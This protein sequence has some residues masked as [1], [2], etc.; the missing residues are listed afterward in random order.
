M[1]QA[2]H[3]PLSLA[4]AAALV[5]GNLCAQSEAQPSPRDVH[6]A[7]VN[8]SH[9]VPIHTQPDDPIGGAYGTWTSRQSYKASFHGDPTFIPVLGKE[10]PHNL[11]FRWRTTS[12]RRGEEELLEPGKR[13]VRSYTDD[14]Y[15]YRYGR[16]TEAYDVLDD[17]LE[18]TFVLETPPGGTGDLV[19]TGQISTPL[20]GTDRA[21]AH[22]AIAFA[23]ASGA[24]IVRYGAAFAL[25]ADGVKLDLETALAGTEIRLVVPDRILREARYPLIL[26]PLISS[27]VLQSSSTASYFDTDIGFDRD[28][29]EYLLV[30]SRW[31]SG[32]DY[33]LFAWIHHRSFLTPGSV[34]FAD[35]TSSWSSS[36]G[37]VASVDQ[38]RKYVFALTRDFGV[39]GAAIRYRVHQGGDRTL[40]T[41]VNFIDPPSGITDH[42]PDVGGSLWARGFS[43]AMIVL[44][45]TNLPIVTGQTSQVMAVPID[46]ATT[47]P[48]QSPEFAVQPIPGAPFTFPI[49]ARPAINKVGSFSRTGGTWVVAMQQTYLGSIAPQ[50]WAIAARQIHSDGTQ[51]PN[52]WQ[53]PATSGTPEH[54]MGPKIAG[55]GNRGA[56][57]H[58][59]VVYTATPD[60]GA[61][62]GQPWGRRVMFARFDWVDG[63]AIQQQN[64]RQIDSTTTGS[65][66][67]GDCSYDR[68]TTSHWAITYSGPAG[69]SVNR[70]GNWG[71]VL[72]SH[73]YGSPGT[74]LEQYNPGGIVWEDNGQFI[75]TWSK[76]GANGGEFVVYKQTYRMPQAPVL[77]GT[78]CSTATLEWSTA[79]GGRGPWTDQQIGHGRTQVEL[80]GA[81]PGALAILLLSLSPPIQ[82]PLSGS[83][84]A[85]GCNLLLSSYVVIPG[86]TAPGVWPFPLPGNY[87][88]ATY[89]FQ[90]WHTDGVGL[91]RGTQRLEVE[92]LR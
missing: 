1:R 10:H 46:T 14:R 79:Y 4:L 50:R 7:V 87:P 69:N 16:V 35:V 8:A 19:V 64:V 68:R 28:N 9:R 48:T 47:L 73:S 65:F 67:V 54:T 3:H 88:E 72:E 49:T 37:C 92:L 12:V 39:S 55:F 41:T 42:H 36:E 62:P 52:A 58:Y 22:G 61:L 66:V 23:D 2:L 74:F 60:S 5:P 24:E 90:A 75:S 31:V 80:T 44:Q 27:T 29:N 57:G 59:G 26:D 34:V 33:D 89:R 70:L 84:I 11:E 86:P 13:P 6:A 91:I 40:H 71:H 15:E 21:P 30:Y 43:R 76:S 77:A 53:L 25:D 38:P 63:G 51:S 18:Q 45:R 83:G 78:G 20:V 81:P 82:L 32:S 56:Y 85:Q 17:G